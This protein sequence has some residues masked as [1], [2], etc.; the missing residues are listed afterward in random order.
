L[1]DKGDFGPEFMS[2][3]SRLYRAEYGAVSIAIV[4]Y[5]VWRGVFLG[6]VGIFATVFW[7]LFPDLVAFIPIGLSPKRREWPRWGSEY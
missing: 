1:T 4:A 5:L 3:G 6:G 2:A 7:A